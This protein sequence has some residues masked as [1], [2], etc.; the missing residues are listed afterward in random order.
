[1]ILKQSVKIKGIKPECVLGIMFAE[2]IWRTSL[3]TKDEMVIT[4]VT[5]GKHMNGSLHYKGYGFDIRT[6]FLTSAQT[7]IFFDALKNH[8]DLEFDIVLEKSHIHI[9]Y[10]PIY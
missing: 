4:S 5:D 10:D 6:N 3:G 2:S 9:E 7:T 1:M 8:M